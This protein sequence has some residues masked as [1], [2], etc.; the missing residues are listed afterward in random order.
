[1]TIDEFEEILRKGHLYNF[2]YHFTDVSNLESIAKHG[3]LSKAELEARGIAVATP[4]GNEW[5]RDADT[6]KGL[7]DYV[8]LCFTSNH[9]CVTLLTLKGESRIHDI[10]QL[11]LTFSEV[12]V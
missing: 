9:P 8:N 3:L 2:L 4:G 12:T 11:A 5:S 1:M 7:D 6:H 10:W